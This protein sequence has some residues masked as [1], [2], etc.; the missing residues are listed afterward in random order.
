MKLKKLAS[1]ALAATL[2][3]PAFGAAA[4]GSAVEPQMA[5]DFEKDVNDF[6]SIFADYPAGDS[7]E[8]FYELRFGRGDVPIDGA[9]KGLY[10]SGNNHSDDLFMGC[11]RQLDGFEPGQL[12]TFLVTFQLATNVDG[13][14]VG[15]GGSPGSSVVVKGGVVMEQPEV[16][17]DGQNYYRL[18]LDKG[19]QMQDGVD[20][21]LLGDLEKTQTQ[22]PGAYEWKRFFFQTQARADRQGRLWLILG[23]DSGFEST[24]TYFLDD[25][26]L[27][28]A[29]MPET[30]ITRGEAVQQMYNSLRPAGDDAP[31]FADIGGNSPYCAAL[32]WAQ[33]AGLISGYGGSVFGAEDPLSIEQAA[34]ILYRYA[35]SPAVDGTAPVQS[36]AWAR[37]AVLWAT[38]QGLL[39]EGDVTRSMS[40]F[41]FARA[42]GKVKNAGA[43][44]VG[45]VM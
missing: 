5:F 44:N 32:G 12:Y 6:T 26:T 3:T 31:A 25:I 20:M 13:G 37:P 29:K 4:P 7:V 38:Q 40:T 22:Y 24:S 11:Y 8:K 36:S 34:V 42:W 27:L 33:R 16:R 19:N 2:I 17:L 30:A 28:W 1:L 15:V 14:L 9:S 45:P 10:L 41:D 39:P 18:C 23:T 35:G 21:T 43:V